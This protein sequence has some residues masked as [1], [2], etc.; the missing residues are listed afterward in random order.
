M[1]PIFGSRPLLQL[2]LVLALVVSISLMVADL[3]SKTFTRVREYLD[4]AIGPV[5]YAVNGHQTLLDKISENLSI[6]S[7]LITENQVLKQEL[8]IK[9]SDLL[10]TGQL[11][12]ENARLRE[13]LGSPVRS[14][15]YKMVTQVLSTDRNPYS[16]QIVI[17]KG[18]SSGV[19]E[20]QPVINEKGVVGQVIAVAQNNS[21]VLLVCDS[22]HAIPVQVLRNDVRVIASGTGCLDDLQLEYLPLNADIQV[23][24]ELV[25]SGLGGRFPEGYPVAVVSSV[26][27]DRQ[28]AMM[29]IHARPVVNVKRLRYLLLLWSGGH[30][31]GVPLSPSEV[32]KIAS[33]R[34][35]VNSNAAESLPSSGDSHE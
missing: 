25:S 5:L 9:N 35:L 33:E 34:Q 23:G 26:T 10:I 7:Q 12:Q 8:L 22:T 21:R 19:Y 32:Q 17:D 4:T 15:E 24:D 6:R 16:D 2:R 18:R 3:H 29:V 27:T 13:L 28:R 20:G 11:L 14:G 31:K 1:K 30:D